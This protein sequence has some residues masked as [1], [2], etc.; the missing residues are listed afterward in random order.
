M[1]AA[2]TLLGSFVM[3]WLL[4]WL[5]TATLIRLAPRVGLIDVPNERKVHTRPIPKGGGVAILL[6]LLLSTLP[7]LWTALLSGE[8]V[9]AFQVVQFLSVLLACAS[10]VAL[11]GLID[12]VWPLPWPLRLGVQALSAVLILYL[13]IPMGGLSFHW[14]PSDGQAIDVYPLLAFGLGVLWIAGMVNAFNMLDNMDALS[15]GVALIVAGSLYGLS[16]LPL[17]LDKESDLFRYLL[18]PLI[19][20]LA[21]FLWFNRPP[22]R[23]F[24]GDC[25]STLLG[26]LLGFTVWRFVWRNPGLESVLAAILIFA[27]PLYDMTTVVLLRLS[28][29]RSPFH[30]DKQHLSH[31][32]V[33]MGL[34]KPMAVLVIHSLA[35]AS[36][37]W[38]LLFVYAV[39]NPTSSIILAGVGLC[40]WLALALFEFWYRRRHK[41]P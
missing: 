18:V 29:G 27:V 5:L 35:L 38:G 30:A 24:M 19:G 2:V 25:G 4:A 28:Q 11:L 20:A 13:W 12:D 14:K 16:G 37:T 3:A 32:L 7:P 17:G 6:A 1:T 26:F 31:R 41:H 23:I 39:G 10:L 33:D 22:A 8:E 9:V 15:G 40:G 36:G 21:G 34:S